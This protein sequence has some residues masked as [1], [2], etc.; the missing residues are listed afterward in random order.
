MHIKSLSVRRVT[1]LPASRSPLHEGF[2]PLWSLA[3]WVALGCCHV[4]GVLQ[5]GPGPAG[6]H[7]Q[8]LL[9]L[10]VSP[11]QQPWGG[12]CHGDLRAAVPGQAAWWQVGIQSD[13]AAIIILPAGRVSRDMAS[14]SR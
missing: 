8:D 10:P 11:C 1:K 9:G 5:R 7:A 2:I 13:G 3:G 14:S 12:P 6:R 4:A